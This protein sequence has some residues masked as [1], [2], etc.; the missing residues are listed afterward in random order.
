MNF[1]MLNLGE[2][3]RQKDIVLLYVD[4]GQMP[5]KNANR[6]MQAVRDQVKPLFTK[7]GFD[8]LFI[9]IRDGQPAAVVDI[10]SKV[11][12][13]LHDKIDNYEDAMKLIGDK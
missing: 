5:P 6:H 9:P 10:V 12:E 13:K 1:E 8:I 11:M 7:R 4:I 3:D 2:Y